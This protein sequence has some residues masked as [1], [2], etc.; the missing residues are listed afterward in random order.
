M[1]TKDIY[2]AI[3]SVKKTQIVQSYDLYISISQFLIYRNTL[4]IQLA[5]KT[6]AAKLGSLWKASKDHFSYMT[7]QRWSQ[8]R[9]VF[10]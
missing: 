1:L 2:E 7:S 6:S 9:Q 5:Y 10:C 3:S 8:V 4:L